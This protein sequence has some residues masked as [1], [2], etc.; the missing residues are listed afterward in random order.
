M[1]SHIYNMKSQAPGIDAERTQQDIK[2][3]I[4]ALFQPDDCVEIRVIKEY[5]GKAKGDRPKGFRTY[6]ESHF[7]LASD[8]AEKAPPFLLD[9]NAQPGV[10]V[11]VAVNPRKKV[12]GDGGEEQA[13]G[14]GKKHVARVVCLHADLDGISPDEAKDKATE[15]GL[16]MM[17]VGSGAGTHAYLLLETPIEL[18]NPEDV[19]RAERL[20]R[21]LSLPFGVK[22]DD[23]GADHCHDLSRILRIPGLTNWPDDRKRA[24]GRIPTLCHLAHVTEQ[25]YRVEELDS[26]LPQLPEELNVIGAPMANVNEFTATEDADVEFENAFGGDAPEYTK[27]IDVPT[28]EEV[29][30]VLK[31][32][33]ANERLRQLEKNLRNIIRKHYKGKEKSYWDG[34]SPKGVRARK[35]VH[36]AWKFGVELNV[37]LD[38]T[39]AKGSAIENDASY[40]RAYQQR[41]LAPR[42]PEG[43]GLRG[44]DIAGC[45]LVRDGCICRRRREQDGD[46]VTPLGNFNAKI[47]EA[48]V[49]DD[50]VETSTTLEIA[51]N[52][53]GGRKLPSVSVPVEKFASLNWVMEL[54]AGKAVLYAGCGNRDHA[55]AAVQILSGEFPERRVYTHTGWRLVD[56]QWLYLHADGAI[57]KDG[58]VEGVEVALPDALKRYQLPTPPEGEELR[59]AV[60]ASL[61]LLDGLASDGTAFAL[62]ASVY[63]SVL[64]TSDHSTFFLGPTGVFK[65][66]LAALGLQHFGSGL[67]ARHLPASWMSTANSLEGIAFAAKDALLVVDDFAPGGSTIDIARQHKDADRLFR[68]QGNGQGRQRMNADSTLRADK[69]PRGMI[70]STGED[71]PRGHSVRARLLLVEVAPGE[72]SV[73]RLTECQ[74]DSALYAKAMA[75]FLRWMATRYEQFQKE[76]P[77]LLADLRQKAL[78]DGLH[79][80]T[81]S[82][83]ASLELGLMTFLRFAHDVEVLDEDAVR[84]F[85]KRG[86]KALMDTAA[87][88]AEHQRDAD[89][90]E[91]FV[92]L[93]SGLLASGRA[94]LYEVSGVRPADAERLGWRR[95]TVRTNTGEEEVWQEQGRL[96]GWI[97][98]ESGVIY[99]EPDAAFAE[100]QRFAT[101]QGTPLPVAQRTLSKR[102]KEK[103]LLAR[104]DDARGKILVRKRVQ[105]GVRKVLALRPDVFTFLDASA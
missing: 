2:R 104:T 37:F 59:D 70:L 6:A 31:E 42:F 101:E 5:W 53:S 20:V 69:S 7:S 30:R 19:V 82:I 77:T 18:H 49:A 75:G 100:V 97:E 67:D 50:G 72:V 52:L 61:G 103:G 89:P 85:W 17:L 26:L 45:Y 66:E 54:A 102:L 38:W 68:A 1:K 92:S 4:N 62:L 81:P 58:N 13:E 83:I 63:R 22:I 73:K 60:R 90:A 88:Q 95:K 80:R 29:V 35:L 44:S 41:Y 16:E 48:V 57:G 55:R 46:V 24:K 99:L 8:L 23:Q 28:L 3:F 56:G 39:R 74:R 76:M 34:Q 25:R 15:L 78:N 40:W 14:G 96:V 93:V 98:D 87:M 33:A 86:R 79:A 27:P 47:V 71:A 84:N 91:R 65:S 94:H 12:I 32:V 64:G 9:W 21:R 51:G 10:N 11:Y 43:Y 36:L 105:E